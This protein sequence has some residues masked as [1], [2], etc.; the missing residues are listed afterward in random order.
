MNE[1]DVFPT[2]VV[3][4][5]VMGRLREEG[6]GEV[7]CWVYSIE[8]RRSRSRAWETGGRGVRG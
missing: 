5:L 2:Y 3:K 7:D 1:N 4:V 6:D 8:N